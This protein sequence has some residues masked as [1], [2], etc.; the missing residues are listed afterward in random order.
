MYLIALVALTAIA[1]CIVGVR[2]RILHEP[3]PRN[4]VFFLPQVRFTDFTDLS[5]RVPHWHE[6]HL[7]SRTDIRPGY[8]FPYSYPAPTFYV[9][10]FFVRLFPLHPLRA[11]LIFA[12][13]SFLLATCFF[14]LRVKHATPRKLPQSRSGPHF[15]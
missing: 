13:L 3:Y 1:W 11:Y 2:G 10:V 9:F 8:P 4:T 15:F 12:L 6:P 14:S 5:Q 7:L